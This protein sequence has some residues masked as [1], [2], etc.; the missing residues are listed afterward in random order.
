MAILLRSAIH[1]SYT[2]HA[3]ICAQTVLNPL[4]KTLHIGRFGYD[5]GLIFAVVH[6]FLSLCSFIC[7]VPFL[8]SNT[9]QFP[10]VRLASE[11]SFFVL[12]LSKMQMG[13][14]LRSLSGNSDTEANWVKID[15]IVRLG[16]SV[17][18]SEDA[19]KGEMMLATPKLVVAFSPLKRYV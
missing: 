14:V 11:R 2:A 10:G 13:E 5:S 7:C 19:E 1:R 4:Q 12:M 16:E 3:K 8:L 18:S 17:N 6:L 15:R 9:P